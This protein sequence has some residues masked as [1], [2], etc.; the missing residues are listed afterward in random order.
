MSG[1]TSRPPSVDESPPS[2]L[3][4]RLELTIVRRL[5]GLLHGDYRGL[6]P[7][8]G[9]EPGETRRYVA[10]DDV[11]RI[12]WNVTARMQTPYYRETIAERE[13]ETWLLTDLSPSLDFGT[14][15]CTKRDM[16][17]AAA[18][19]IAFLT[20]R[21]Q[22]RLGAVLLDR[23]GTK[24]LP[25]RTGRVHLRSVMHR[26]ITAPRGD[27]GGGTDLAAGINRVG[28]AG[29]RRGLVVL[30]SDFLAP[31]DWETALRSLAARHEVLA[32]EVLDPREVELPN[33]GLMVVRDP[34]SGRQREVRT[35]DPELR[36]RYA[37]AAKQQ[38]DRIA[39][40]LRRAGADHLQLR[41]DRDWLVD[42]VRFVALRKHRIDHLRRTAS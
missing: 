20:A 2:E 31:P 35:S 23:E 19:T 37:L 9:T 38:R 34:E 21:A 36:A 1:A 14:V 7:G 39:Q 30:V 40:T 29:Q 26:I 17:V 3:L 27:G 8:H 24:V 11:R 5:D 4:R 25:A 41:T 18:G 32:I 6:V 10:G 12:D 33:V 42:L 15:R 22:N 16:A 13:L 28:R